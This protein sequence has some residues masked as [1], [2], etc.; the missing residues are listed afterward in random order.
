MKNKTAYSFRPIKGD[1]DVIHEFREGLAFVRNN[2][3]EKNQ[4]ISIKWVKWS[5]HWITTVR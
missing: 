1:Y 2:I 4:V 3:E 5:S